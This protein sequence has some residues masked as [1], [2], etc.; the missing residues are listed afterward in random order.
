MGVAITSCI[1]AYSAFATLHRLMP[2]QFPT[3][4]I[5]E[6]NCMQS[7]ASAAGSMTSAGVVNAIPALMMLNAAVLPLDFATRC[8]WLIPWII[9][10]SW[11][12]VFLAVPAK[13]QMINIEQLPYP[14]G[15]A[16]ATTLRT[17]HASAKGAGRQAQALLTSGL[18]GGVITS[19]GIR[20]CP[21]PGARAGSG[22]A[23]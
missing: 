13:R 23:R 8:L 3:F 10:I 12:G 2:K 14:S 1:L 20:R 4:S 7:C 6:N 5:L 17:L 16:A 22:S 19:S 21:R 11:M 18:I 15:I 9:V